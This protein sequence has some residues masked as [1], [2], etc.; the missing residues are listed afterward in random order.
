MVDEGSRWRR[1]FKVFNCIFFI[2]QSI[3]CLSGGAR[4]GP[5]RGGILLLG[6]LV[7]FRRRGKHAWKGH[8][9]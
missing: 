2:G 5:R 7:V 3:P 8:P 1:A 4:S 9:S 6:F